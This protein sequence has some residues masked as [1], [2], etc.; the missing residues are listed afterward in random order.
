MNNHRDLE[1]NVYAA[2][3][4]FLGSEEEPPP[5]VPEHPIRIDHPFEDAVERFERIAEEYAPKGSM[6]RNGVRVYGMDGV[7]SKWL[8]LRDASEFA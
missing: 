8:F 1:W 2:V 6:L 3:R 5:A 7:G 4:P